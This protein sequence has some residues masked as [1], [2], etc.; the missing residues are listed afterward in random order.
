MKLSLNLNASS[1]PTPVVQIATNQVT[2]INP[3]VHDATVL[4]ESRTRGGTCG[5][6]VIG[7]A[8]IYLICCSL[9]A[10]HDSVNHLRN[11][12]KSK[13]GRSSNIL[14]LIISSDISSGYLYHSKIREVYATT[15]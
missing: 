8:H 1:C 5:R 11:Y 15:V 9:S 13:G 7:S 14:I 4:K 10:D 6:P 3:R 12:R 2:K